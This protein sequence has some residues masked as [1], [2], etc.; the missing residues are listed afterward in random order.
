MGMAGAVSRV[1]RAILPDPLAKEVVADAVLVS[2]LA[3]KIKSLAPPVDISQVMAQVEDLLDRSVAPVPYRIEEHDPDKLFD[4]SQIDFDKLKDKFAKG[5]KRTE[6]EKLRALLNQKLIQMAKLNPS[7]AD[8]LERF[9]KLIEKYNSASLNI[10][11]FFA[12]LVKLTQDLS[13][14][15]QRAMREG[16][17][18]E[19][20]AVFD[21]LTK[22]EP[23]LSD[24]ERDQVKKVCKTLLETLKAEKLVIDWRNKSQARAVVR[25]TVQVIFDD[26]LPEIYDEP[27]YD[28]KCM[29][30]FNHIYSAYQGGGQSIYATA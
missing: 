24:K 18:E 11:A 4:L 27:L 30:T 13:K 16:L 9:E 2:V 28:A 29:A 10:E 1:Y 3:Q 21:I 17:T 23:A 14:E 20:L 12:E 26:G 8:F 6:A 19:E 22:P 5:R 15:D 25:Q 7:R